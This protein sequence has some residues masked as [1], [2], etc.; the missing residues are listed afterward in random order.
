MGRL[1]LLPSRTACSYELNWEYVNQ[2][3]T[4]CQTFT[5]IWKTLNMQYIC[6]NSLG[7]FLSSAVFIKRWFGW[8]SNMK[9]DLPEICEM[10]KGN[11]D[12]LAWDGTKIAMGVD[13]AF[14][15]PTE[16]HIKQNPHQNVQYDF[17][18]QWYLCNVPKKE[19]KWMIICCI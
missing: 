8:D 9:I 19:G 1:F 11:I 18:L 3:I 15:T 5:G 14:I 13:V 10:C 6:S 2:V 12:H 17:P 4:S 16:Q 7:R